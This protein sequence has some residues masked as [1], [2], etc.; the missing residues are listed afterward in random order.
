MKSKE[1]ILSLYTIGRPLAV[2]HLTSGIIHATFKVTT[3]RGVF[4]LQKVNP[5]FSPLVMEDISVVL[6]YLKEKG[7]TVMEIVETHSGEKYVED[8]QG[9]W[10][11]FIYISGKVYEHIHEENAAQSAGLLLGAYHRL[12]DGFS[13]TFKHVRSIK[14]NIPLLF[15]AYQKA[16][17][18]N[19]NEEITALIPLINEMPKLDLPSH[20]R[21]N[22][23]HGDAKISNFIFSERDPAHAITMVDFDDCGKS[24][25]ILH[26]LGGF[27]RSV[28]W[29]KENGQELFSLTHFEA[30]LRGYKE[31]SRDFLLE[32]EWRYLPQVVRL[33]LLQ[34]SSRFVRDYFEDKY[35]AWDTSRFPSRRAHNA[36]RA[37]EHIALY[38][39]ITA[40]EEKI[41]TLVEQIRQEKI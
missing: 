25:N 30:A 3:D 32:E 2:E 16:I 4:I 10:R 7:C 8:T 24:Y 11:V 9:F 27:F 18:G 38:K 40:K 26:E 12:L 15:E 33:N 41:R 13:Y 35:F 28:C 34:L 22:V 1:E 23:H 39:D 17:V 36:Y 29:V 5:I 14:H 19:T 37:Q 6:T 20:F 31:S 21:K